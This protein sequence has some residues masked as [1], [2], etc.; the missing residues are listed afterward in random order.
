MR[1]SLLL[2]FPPYIREAFSDFQPIGISYLASYVLDKNPGL[3][4]R[5][6]DFTVE[7]FSPEKVEI[8]VHFKYIA[9]EMIVTGTSCPATQCI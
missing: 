9:L 2:V 4:L 6:I 8:T 5:L 3:D 7:K 1:N